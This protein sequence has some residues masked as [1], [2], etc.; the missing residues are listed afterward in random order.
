M[1]IEEHPDFKKAKES[2]QRFMLAI[3]AG[4]NATKAYELCYPNASKATC[5]SK[6]HTLKNKYSHILAQQSIVST[7]T[8]ERIGNQTLEN[9]ALMA[10]ADPAE[11]FDEQGKPRQL[12]DIPKNLRLSLSEVEIDGDR[13]RYKMGGKQRSL[14][15]LAKAV[16]LFDDKSEINISLITEE[17]RDNK[18]REILINA[19]KRES[20]DAGDNE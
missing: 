18:I 19:V 12:K 11:L 4:H 2:H 20:G 9:I 5:T 13:V 14:E 15:I 10:F 8:L 7:A 17:Q 1:S 16:K 3:A 6:G